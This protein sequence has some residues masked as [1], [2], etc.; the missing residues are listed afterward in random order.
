ML[1][2]CLFVNRI[3]VQ[4][5]ADTAVGMNQID[6]AGLLAVLT[7]RLSGGETDPGS[8]HAAPVRGLR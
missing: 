5:P 7:C 1:G 3:T 2:V 4:A 8:Q 6:V